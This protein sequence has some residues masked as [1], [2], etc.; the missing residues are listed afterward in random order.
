M[1]AIVEPG[2]PIAVIAPSHAY[3]LQKF[4]TG[5]AIARKHGHVLH[6]LEGNLQPHRYFA[7]SDALRLEQLVHALTSKDFGAVWVVRG[8]SGLARL[9]RD[10]PW[11]SLPQRP[12]IG[13]SD[14]TSLLNPLAQR[15]GS[16]VVHGPVLHS[17]GATDDTS[18]GHLFDLLAGRGLD[19]L[20][21][22]PL[23][24][25]QGS[26]PLFGGNLCLLATACGT[27]FS[28]DARG[29]ILVIEEVGEHPY[30]VDR[31]LAQLRDCGVF[32]DLAG[33]ALGEFKDCKPPA[34]SG[35]GLN[36]IFLEFFGDLGIPVLADLPIGHG[37]ANRAFPLGVMGTIDGKELRW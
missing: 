23:V 16:P 11:G 33:V 36:D 22:T 9:L 27:D 37:S 8:G 32:D 17:L 35:W 2:T 3:N 12:V 14:T 26:G 19:P 7:G 30:R 25:G 18:I 20:E 10:V 21:G 5:L 24:S 15:V 34:D 4:E 31:S 6:P 29:A 13:F 1:T 28:L